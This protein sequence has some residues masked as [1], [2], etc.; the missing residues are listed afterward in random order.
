M[1]LLAWSGRMHLYGPSGTT[2]GK[3]K[4]GCQKS[5]V[6]S[7]YRDRRLDRAVLQRFRPSVIFVLEVSQHASVGAP[8]SF[9]EFRI[10][11]QEI[12]RF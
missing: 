2:A 3:M 12:K 6:Q 9:A 4:P 11:F 1:K 10:R 8:C 5:I 7:W